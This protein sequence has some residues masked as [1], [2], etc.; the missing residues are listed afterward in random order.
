MRETLRTA[1]PYLWRYRRGLAVGIATIL[2]MELVAVSLPLLIRG[3]V[4]AVTRGMPLPVVL[5]MAA[6]MLAAAGVKALL[7]FWGRIA[8]IG[9]SRDVEYDLRDALFRHLVTL[10]PDFYRRTRTGDLMARATNDLNAVR[11]MI[12]PG[13]LNWFDA[14]FAFIP[15]FIVMLLVDWRLTLVALLP[16]PL[17]SL[18]VVW[19][20]QAI[21]TRFE[22]IQEAFSDISSGVQENVAGVRVVRAF[23]QEAQEMGRF[24]RL[25][26]AYVDLNLRLAVVSGVFTPLLQFLVGLTSLVVLW[27]GGYRL[28]QGRL[29]LGSYVMFNTYMV[30]L[31]KPMVA[32]GRVMN[33][34]QQGTASLRRIQA[35]M[36]EQ[37]TLAPPAVPFQI[38]S[39]VRGE[40]RL[41]DI[42]VRFR[43]G[44]ALYGISLH[45]PAGATVA[46]V[47]PTGSGKS[48][49][50]SLIPRLMDPAS[51]EVRIDGVPARD[52][53]PADL[54]RH[55][56]VVPQETFLFSATL[57]ENLTFGAVNVSDERMRWAAGIAGLT[58]D[59]EGFPHGFQTIVG[60]RG[61]SLS[62]GQKQRTAIARAILRDPRILI[63]DDALASVDTLT[64]ERILT[65]LREVMRDRTT[66]LIS[67]RASTVRH[68]DA[69]VVLERG[70]ITQQ[71]THAQ[72]VAAGG[73]YAD[74]YRDQLIEDELN[75]LSA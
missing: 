37:P 38:V 64:E 29:T 45:V 41:T 31:V 13:L 12:G 58:T 52:Y 23:A 62:G 56:G 1:W 18:S 67:H 24:G 48:T 25:D 69:I 73:Y 32:I 17:V 9:I 59:V 57:A 44:P 15:A 47:G 42:S 40:V 10:S 61:I 21:H 72:L 71:G 28:L 60:E 11:M 51:G 7:Q 63:L 5:R 26:A 74:C 20:G 22:R 4:D 34:L 50:A 70:C 27:F 19:F 14:C 46:I 39:P 16:A 6:L 8:F 55:V 54:R 3:G 43:S 53:A 75:V 36:E 30:M 35:L 68:A 65:G 49:P 66:I 33:I 2:L